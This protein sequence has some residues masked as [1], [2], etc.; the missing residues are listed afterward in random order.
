MLLV[1]DDNP[2][3]I[4]PVLNLFRLWEAFKVGGTFGLAWLAKLDK[5]F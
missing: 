2:S 4:E 3:F 1:L 5:L